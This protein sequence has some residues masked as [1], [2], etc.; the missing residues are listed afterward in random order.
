MVLHLDVPRL[1]G[2]T[3]RAYARHPETNGSA[4]SCA[5]LRYNL[6]KFMQ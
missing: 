3:M 2:F 5:A 6:G 1:R 4:I